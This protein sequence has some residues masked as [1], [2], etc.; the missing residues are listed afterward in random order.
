MN[1]KRIIVFSIL[2]P[3]VVPMIIIVGIF[4]LLIF[5]LEYAL[6]GKFNQDDGGW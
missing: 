1:W 5:G 3:I 2:S 6:T 4:L